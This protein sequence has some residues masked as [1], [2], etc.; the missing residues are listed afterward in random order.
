MEQ[1]D[2]AM[3]GAGFAMLALGALGTFLFLKRRL[4]EVRWFHRAAIWAIGLPFLANTTGWIVTEIGRQPW[5][6]FGLLRT[7]DSVSPTVSSGAV[8]TTL[9]GFTVLYGALAVV[10]VWLLARFAKTGPT[11]ETTAEDVGHALAY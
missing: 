7:A 9:V 5:T 1:W 11:E 2:V 8:V 4:G 3:V 10:D 6:A